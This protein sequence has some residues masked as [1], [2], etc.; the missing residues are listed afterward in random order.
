[1]AAYREAERLLRANGIVKDMRSI[2]RKFKEVNDVQGYRRP[3]SL[4]RKARPMRGS[5]PAPSAPRY[6]LPQ[7]SR[8]D[9]GEVASILRPE[10]EAVEQQGQS[11]ADRPLEPVPF[12]D[13]LLPGGLPSPQQSVDE[14]STEVSRGDDLQSHF[15]QTANGGPVLP[16]Q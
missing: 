11:I 1:M 12:T 15:E 3:S 13:G 10:A 2:R 4:S 6:I 9:S 16:A 7:S 14:E 5:R 8:Q